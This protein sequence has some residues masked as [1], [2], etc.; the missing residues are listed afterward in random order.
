M[1]LAKA[2]LFSLFGPANQAEIGILMDLR[3]CVV[4]RR[5]HR[6]PSEPILNV[7][8]LLHDTECT[9]AGVGPKPT[10]DGPSQVPCGSIRFA[11][12]Y[13]TVHGPSFGPFVYS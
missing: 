12:V 11:G 5:A 9:A 8:C 2:S 4:G 10:K 6:L 3:E 1:V 7:L 13:Q